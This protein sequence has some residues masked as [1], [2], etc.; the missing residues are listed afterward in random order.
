MATWQLQEAKAKFSEMLDSLPSEGPH[1]VTRRGQREAMLVSIDEWERMSK[2]RP[3][4][5]EVLM[6]G[7]KFD[8]VLPKRGRLRMRTR[9]KTQ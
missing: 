5:L 8:V 2:R 1:V 9:Q 4:P 7:P 3:T 6:S